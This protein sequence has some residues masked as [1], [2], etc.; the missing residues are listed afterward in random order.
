MNN[1]IVILQ[2]ILFNTFE[3]VYIHSE[4][5][6]IVLILIKKPATKDSSHKRMSFQIGVTYS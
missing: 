5:I 1:S 2:N 4:C 3:L 6:T